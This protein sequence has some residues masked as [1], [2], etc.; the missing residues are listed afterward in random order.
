MSGPLPRPFN[1]SCPYTILPPPILFFQIPPAFK[2]GG[3]ELCS[4]ER[5]QHIMLFSQSALPKSRFTGEAKWTLTGL[6]FQTGVKI[7]FVYMK[8]HF[9]YISKRPNILM[10]M[11]WHFISGIVYMMKF[12]FC[13]N[14][15]YENHTSTEFQ[16][17]M[18]IKRNI[19]RACTYSFCFG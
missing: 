8:F 4:P 11:W 16:T 13:Q 6:R 17:H 14:D 3:F 1:K 19:Q 18:C 15:R 5:W 12:H 9:D 10:D 7:G 2:K